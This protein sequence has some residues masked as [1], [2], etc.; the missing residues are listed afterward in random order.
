VIIV[1]L[2]NAKMQKQVNQKDLWEGQLYLTPLNSF[3]SSDF[4]PFSSFWVI[5]FPITKYELDPTA[6]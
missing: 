6:A 2:F 3:R 5:D 1:L 4:F